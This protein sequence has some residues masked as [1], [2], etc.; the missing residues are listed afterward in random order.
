MNDF[1]VKALM[2]VVSY[3]IRIMEVLK[4]QRA[5]PFPR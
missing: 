2:G 3:G 5:A 1:R 4:Q